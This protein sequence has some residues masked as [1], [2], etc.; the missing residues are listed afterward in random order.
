MTW[1][2]ETPEDVAFRQFDVC[3][4]R[5]VRIFDTAPTYNDGEAE[6]ILGKCLQRVDRAGVKVFTKWGYRER[7]YPAQK[8]YNRSLDRLGIESVDILFDHRFGSSTQPHE[9]LEQLEATTAR[10][11]GVSNCAAW[12]ASAAL[13]SHAIKAIQPMYSLAKR[14]AEIELLP[15]AQMAGLEVYSYSPLASGWLAGSRD[16]LSYRDDRYHARYKYLARSEV[17]RFIE[18]ARI[19]SVHPSALALAWAASHPA[20]T[21]PIIGARTV[22][23]LEQALGCVNVN[24]NGMRGTLNRIFTPPPPATDRSDEA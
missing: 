6:R 12:Q 18:L 23:Q 7:S 8:S 9:D 14:T 2:R 24:V 15:M 3:L 11:I 19:H 21:A 16:P 13:D 1:G 20:V 22:E 4:E 5:N 17:Y 10:A